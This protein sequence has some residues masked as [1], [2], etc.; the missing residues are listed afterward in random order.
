MKVEIHKYG[1]T[2]VANVK[3]IKNIAK[4]TISYQLENNVRVVLVL[5][6]MNDST[7]ILQDLARGVSD[8]PN[9][10]IEDELLATGEVVSCSLMALAL[11]SLGCN[12]EVIKGEKARIETN[13]WFGNACIDRV[14]TSY[15]KTLLDQEII[16]VV[17]GFQGVSVNNKI[18]T[19]GRGGS[20][21]TAIVLAQSLKAKCHI[22]T[23]VDGV[24]N[25]DPRLDSNAVLLSK[26]PA[27]KMLHMTRLGAQILHPR[28][29]E[30]IF[31]SKVECWIKPA[32]K[33]N[34]SGTL[35]VNTDELLPVDYLIVLK[36]DV[37]QLDVNLL[38]LHA[39]KKISN[40]IKNSSSSLEF[41]SG[42][43]SPGTWRFLINKDELL[44]CLGLL[45][46]FKYEYVIKDVIFKLTILSSNNSKIRLN[47]DYLIEK[48]LKGLD[49]SN[50]N[51]STKSDRAVFMINSNVDIFIEHLKSLNLLKL[52]G[53]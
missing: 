3:K 25:I 2:S 44:W 26:I 22:Y 1:G 43:E 8:V 53:A 16:P 33:W 48:I 4:R 39:I 10:L 24:Y 45:D 31:K 30:Q 34:K 29:A 11:V 13:D 52:I 21:I 50:L 38:S 20:D 5:S 36:K 9:L 23:D 14:D 32:H 17:T 28:A 47:N 49:V 37:V 46:E 42:S 41:L 7:N 15:L 35:I 12:A 6:A 18:T 27:L 40:I 19:L 51:I